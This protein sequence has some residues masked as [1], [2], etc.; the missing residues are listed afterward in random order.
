MGNDYKK[1]H[2]RQV[3]HRSNLPRISDEAKPTL[4]T[5][6]P[7]LDQELTPIFELRESA[8][9]DLTVNVGSGKI[10]NS[11]TGLSRAFFPIQSLFFDFPGGTVTFPATTGGV[12]TITPGIDSTITVASGNYLAVLIQ[13]DSLGQLSIAPGTE[14][15]S[16]VDAVNAANFPVHFKKVLPI[17]YVVLY[18]QTGTIQNIVNEVIT[19]FDGGGGGGGSGDAN[20][21]LERLKNRADA[22]AFEY[23][24]PVIFASTEDELVD[25]TSTAEFSVV[26]SNY[27]FANIGDFLLSK[28]MFDVPFLESGVLPRSIE[29]VNYWNLDALDASATYEVSRDGGN[30][31]QTVSMDRIG[32][33]D[34]YY[35]AHTFSPEPSNSFVQVVGG[36]VAT[37]TDFTDANE[38]SR[39]FTLTNS[40]NIKKI[41]ANMTVAGA[42]SG[43]V[44]AVV[45]KDDG[46]GSPSTALTDRVGQSSFVSIDTM[47]TGNVEFDIEAS[48]PA[49]DYHV[50]FKTEDFYKINYTGSAGA[51]KISIDTDGGADIIYSLEGMELDLRVKITGG[52]AGVFCEGFGIFYQSE[53]RVSPVDGNIL[54]DTVTFVG[55]VDNL[56]S[57]AINFTPEPRLLNVYEIGTGQTYRYGAFVLDG[58]QVIFEPNTF[59]KPE[60]ITLEFLQIHG[61]SFDNN[62]NNR[63]LLAA[64]HLGSTDPNIDLSVSGRGF[65][66]R[67][68]D[69][70]LY[71]IVIQD[72]GIGFDIYE[73]T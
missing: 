72:G 18:N 43:F 31:W 28:Q 35:G 13:V 27:E 39:Q 46:F 21:L 59:N 57:F 20:E 41:V 8:T 73:V 22:S 58:N 45:V 17:G 61:S 34:T 50:I 14:A 33:S 63:A 9:P 62:D 54:R 56:N 71:E 6:L 49:G 70:T 40:T 2:V 42:P 1:I 23:M 67:S 68:D 29:L 5:I 38:L 10:Q 7:R 15:A 4:K 69:G 52:T 65:L 19:Q 60:T 51:N 44:Y 37:V 32:V 53:E 55:N 36:A 24:T 47:A 3:E 48:T 11:D 66:Q 64:N 16:A 26:D 30:N 25:A 12:V